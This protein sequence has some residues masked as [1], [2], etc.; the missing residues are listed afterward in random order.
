MDELRELLL[1]K[2]HERYPGDIPA[3]ISDRFNTEWE[4]LTMIAGEDDKDKVM[5]LYIAIM[6]AA[7]KAGQPVWNC[8]VGS[9][10]FLFYLIDK[11]LNP[12]EPHW[13]C[14]KCG[15]VETDERAELCFDLPVK[16]CPG[17][18]TPMARDG[19]HGSPEESLKGTHI[20]IRVNEEFLD[21]ANDAALAALKGHKVFQQR[22]NHKSSQD[23]YRSYYYSD[24]IK[25]KDKSLIHQDESGNEYILVEDEKFCSSNLCSITI[26]AQIGYPM[27]KKPI[28]MEEWIESKP[29]IRALVQRNNQDRKERDLYYP[30]NPD[31]QLL[32]M[33]DVLQPETW[34]ALIRLLCY[35]RGNYTLTGKNTTQEKIELI[36]DSDFRNVLYSRES[37][38]FYLHKQGIPVILDWQMVEQLRIGRKGWEMELFGEKTPLL[39]KDELFNAVMYLW[40][41]MSVI[42]WLW[43]YFSKGE[44][45]TAKILERKE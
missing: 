3:F 26:V 12:L 28:S 13:Q 14:R 44:K 25:K 43:R 4:Y 1:R 8:S 39:E 23:D 29:D 35:A 5:F 6:E 42:N 30:E 22:S 15:R 31:E 41:R 9:G 17:C 40:P 45:K 33:I 36:R 34:T 10:S 18:K 11:G 2:L 32:E 37:L 16:A 21:T 24:K 20:E 38:Q 7:E 27:L 19:I